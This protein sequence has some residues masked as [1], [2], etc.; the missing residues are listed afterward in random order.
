M[1]SRV[2]SSYFVTSIFSLPIIK[3]AKGDKGNPGHIS[4]RTR[5]GNNFP[6]TFVEGP[7][8]PPGEPGR[9]GDKVR[10]ISV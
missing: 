9:P 8:G 1:D 5:N 10:Q 7:P 3:G 2:T 6:T 4:T